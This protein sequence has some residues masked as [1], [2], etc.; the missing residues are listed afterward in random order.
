MKT[1]IYSF[2]GLFVFV[3]VLA[4]TNFNY[5]ERSYEFSRDPI[6][7]SGLELLSEITISISL[8]VFKTKYFLSPMP[9]V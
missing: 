4:N 5:P 7:K 2:S 6:H 8:F 9:R 1:K 3:I